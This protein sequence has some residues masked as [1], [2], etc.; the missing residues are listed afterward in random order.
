[1]YSDANQDRHVSGGRLRCNALASI[2]CILT[3]EVQY[4]KQVT[5]GCDDGCNALASIKCILTDTAMYAEATD[6][7]VSCNALASIK[8]ILTGCAFAAGDGR[9]HGCNALASIKCIL[10]E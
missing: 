4:H 10:T 3:L 8:C 1:M 2:K 6:V 5:H 7:K 9:I